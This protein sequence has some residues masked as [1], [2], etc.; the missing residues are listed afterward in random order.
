[1]RPR[2][3][4]LFWE[5]EVGN[6]ELGVGTWELGVDSVTVSPV[7]LRAVF[8]PMPTPFKDGEVDEPA[9]RKN[10]RHWMTTGL[11]GIVALGTNGEASL[12]DDDEADRV[13]GAVRSEVPAG[14]TLIAGVGRESTRATIAAARRAAAAG[15]DAVL[16][17]TP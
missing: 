7:N 8:P 11:G 1:M 5:L 14:R 10:V 12:L 4:F 13:L 6:W 15:A 3:L 17:R 9:I 2:P 16:A